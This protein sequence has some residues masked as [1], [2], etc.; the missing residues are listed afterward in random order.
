MKR[1]LIFIFTEIDHFIS[2]LRQY[3]YRVYLQNKMQLKLMSSSHLMNTLNIMTRNRSFKI[4]K[5]III[6]DLNVLIDLS[7]RITTMNVFHFNFT[8]F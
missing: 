4:Y 5:K 1:H 7:T 6:T 8:S 2:S 3:Y